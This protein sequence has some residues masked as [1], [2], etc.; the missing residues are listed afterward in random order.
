MNRDFKGATLSGRLPDTLPSNLHVIHV[1]SQKTRYIRYSVP[2]TDEMVIGEIEVYSDSA[3]MEKVPVRV[4]TVFDRYRHPERVTDGDLV[5]FFAAPLNC[6]SIILETERPEIV[7]AIGFVPRND[8]NFVWPGHRY[9]LLYFDSPEK[10]WQTADEKVADGREITMS[11]PEGALYWL[12]D[13]TKGRE[14]EIFVWRD[15]RQ[16]FVH[17][18]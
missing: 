6:R 14:E 2:G 11:A 17:D 9:R 13:L 1:P 8:D 7:S 16:T 15:N 12:R 3:A 18:L 10:G 5:S 4:T